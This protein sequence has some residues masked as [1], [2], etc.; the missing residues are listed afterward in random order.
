MATSDFWKT[1]I[2]LSSGMGPLRASSHV[3]Q[4]GAIP[5]TTRRTKKNQKQME[6]EEAKEGGGRQ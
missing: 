6:E 2:Q 3:P 1:E 4:Y 5:Y